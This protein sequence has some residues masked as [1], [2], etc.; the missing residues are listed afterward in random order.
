MERCSDSAFP[1]QSLGSFGPHSLEDFES[2]ALE[3]VSITVDSYL[4]PGDDS[5]GDSLRVVR[6][7]LPRL[8]ERGILALRPGTKKELRDAAWATIKS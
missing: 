1:P 8:Q 4:S 5:H 7:C 3:G 6:S 2:T